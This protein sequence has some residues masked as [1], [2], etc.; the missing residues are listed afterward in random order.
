MKR[1]AVICH[2][3]RLRGKAKTAQRCRKVVEKVGESLRVSK[4]ISNFFIIAQF[5]HPSHI[6]RRK[7]IQTFSS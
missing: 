4:I 3:N 7:Y 1:V 6:Y 2:I 5:R